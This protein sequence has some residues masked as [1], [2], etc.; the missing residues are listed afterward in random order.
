MSVRLFST[1]C[2]CLI[3]T[4]HAASADKF[5]IPTISDGEIRSAGA[6]GVSAETSQ[7]SIQT[8]RSGN[9]N[10]RHG[11]FV[12]DL[13]SIPN[14]AAINSV[15]LQLT[16]AGLISN[17]SETA[18]VEFHGYASDSVV[19]AVDFDSPA[20]GPSTLLASETFPTGEASPSIG[21]TITVPLSTNLFENLVQSSDPY[22]TLRSETVNFVAL[23]VHSLENVAGAAPPTLLIRAESGPLL[24]DFNNNGL[25]D[26]AD[27]DLLSD[28]VGGLDV[29]LDLNSDGIVSDLDRSVW[30]EDLS[31]TF[32][33]DADLNQS[34]N[35]SDFLA[36]SQSYGSEAGWADG[37]FDGS[38]DV[39]F[40]DFLLL[41]ANFGSRASAAAVPEPSA[42]PMIL[43]GTLGF[44]GFRRRD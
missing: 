7:S 3:A 22:I 24:G 29:V 20:S 32:F 42:L 4:I 18:T 10:I 8:L 27:I 28:G 41:A 26:A 39:G 34:V 21:S 12:F 44:L 40:S 1:V 19:N 14:N 15:D 36:L 11:A 35:F 23:N 25:L 38:G 16:L 33:G 37:D 2:V 6:L 5:S 13:S 43:I 9:S 31:G 17:I 30:V